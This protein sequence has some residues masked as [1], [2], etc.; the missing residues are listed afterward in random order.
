MSS[1]AGDRQVWFRAYI[2]RLK[3]LDPSADNATIE[4]APARAGDVAVTRYR[5][6]FPDDSIYADDVWDFAAGLPLAGDKP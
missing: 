4:H 3:T 6:R 1:S 5:E 2:A